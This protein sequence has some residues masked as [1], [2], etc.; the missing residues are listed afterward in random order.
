MGQFTVGG[1]KFADLQPSSADTIT[2]ED[3]PQALTGT[4]PTP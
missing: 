2:A 4:D 1:M 3:A